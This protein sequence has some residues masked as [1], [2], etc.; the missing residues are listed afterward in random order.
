[1]AVHSQLSL[2]YREDTYQ[3]DL[4]VHFAQAGLSFESQKPYEVYDSME[5]GSLIGYYIPDFVVYEKV[6]VENKALKR[7]GNS[8]LAQ[9]IG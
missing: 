9:V 3:R 5:D 8:H 6:V 7:L 1:M 2:A 4:H